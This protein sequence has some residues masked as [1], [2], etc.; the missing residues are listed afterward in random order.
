MSYAENATF[1][2]A[3]AARHCCVEGLCVEGL[4]L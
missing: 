2:S 1:S 3:Y 4:I